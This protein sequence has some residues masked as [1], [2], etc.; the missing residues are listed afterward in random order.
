[1]LVLN[2]NGVEGAASSASYILS[3]RGY[4]MTQPANG[5]RADAPSY[6]YFRTQV[7][8]NPKVTGAKPA[9]KK[10]AALFGSADAVKLV[11][12]IRRLSNG[13]ML[14]VVLGQTFHGRLASAPIDQT[15]Q[16]QPANVVSGASAAVDLLRRYRQPDR[17]PADGADPDRALVLDRLRDADPRLQDRSGQEA[18]GGAADVPRRRQPVLGRPDDRLEGRAG[19]RGPQLRPE[20]RRP[21]VR[22]LLQRPAPAHGRAQHRRR[23]ATGSSTRCSTGSRTRR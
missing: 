3:Q 6:D 5:L 2:G 11:P 21:P 13:S 15:P 7:Y 14:V 9:A 23:D 8:F 4:R 10:L 12:K 18:L 20:D 1:M 19:A 16:R 22:A 17:L